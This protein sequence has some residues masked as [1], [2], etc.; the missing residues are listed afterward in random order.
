[1]GGRRKL[2]NFGD[3]MYV[4]SLAVRAREHVR[5]REVSHSP[6]AFEGGLKHSVSVNA[7]KY[8]RRRTR[9]K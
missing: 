9:Y 2:V 4:A 8:P 6:V 7:A 5:P 3:P 1:M